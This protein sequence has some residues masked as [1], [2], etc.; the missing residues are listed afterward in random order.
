MII[1]AD[2]AN[3]SLIGNLKDG[4]AAVA[5]ASSQGRLLIKKANDAIV[6]YTVDS[7][8][9]SVMVYVGADKIQIANSHGAITID[10][11]GIALTSGQ[12]ALVLDALG[13]AKLTG[14]QAAVD[15]N[16]A[17]I[18]GKIMTMIGTLATPTTGVAYGPPGPGP[19][20]LS[21]TTVFV[22]P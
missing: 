3:P 21:S 4:E 11:N 18:A 12:A 7:S 13:N 5:S 1:S 2:N 15:G 14:L 22:S 17:A 9:K 8:G 19:V 10:S 20:V 6:L 16:V